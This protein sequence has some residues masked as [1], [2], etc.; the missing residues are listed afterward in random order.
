M[1]LNLP[2]GGS[3]NLGSLNFGE[4]LGWQV[5]RSYPMSF[6]WVLPSGLGKGLSVYS[7]PNNQ[8]LNNQLFDV[9]SYDP[10]PTPRKGLAQVERFIAG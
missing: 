9:N 4:P 3:Q 1:G 5:S 6:E 10:G 8:L 7:E 2:P